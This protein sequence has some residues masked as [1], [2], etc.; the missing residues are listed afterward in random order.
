MPDSIAFLFLH[1]HLYVAMSRVRGAENWGTCAIR[2]PGSR[3]HDSKTDE[4]QFQGGAEKQHIV[5]FS[6]KDSLYLL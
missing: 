6:P 2:V 5:L 3:Q 1:L 4:A